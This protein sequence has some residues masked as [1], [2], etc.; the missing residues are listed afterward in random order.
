MK[1]VQFPLEEAIKD[2][3]WKEL[4]DRQLCDPCLG[5]LVGHLGHGMSNKERGTLLRPVLGL[6]EP[7]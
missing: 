5:R 7:G 3:A 1:E 4:G 6:S 2:I